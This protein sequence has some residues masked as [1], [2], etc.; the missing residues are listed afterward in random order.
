M[1]LGSINYSSVDVGPYFFVVEF[2]TSGLNIR[3]IEIG[4]QHDQ[5][6][7]LG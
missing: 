4:Q 1:R 6:D 2:V 3:G 5:D 7:I